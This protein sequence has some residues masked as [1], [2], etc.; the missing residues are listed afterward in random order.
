MTRGNTRIKDTQ[1]SRKSQESQEI[2]NDLLQQINRNIKYDT[3]PFNLMTILISW[4][5]HT[6]SKKKKKTFTPNGFEKNPRKIEVIYS[7]HGGG[8]EGVNVGR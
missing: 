1:S 7:V 5:G 8:F 3:N 4:K 2:S 6:V